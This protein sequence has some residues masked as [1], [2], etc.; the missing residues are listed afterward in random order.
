MVSTSPDPDTPAGGTA[1]SERR[2]IRRAGAQAEPATEA[3]AE[4]EPE[5]EPAAVADEGRALGDQIVR[6]DL[7]ATVV[8]GVVSIVAVVWSA[9]VVAAVVVDI[10]LFVAGCAAFVYAYFRGIGRSR[11]EAVSL[12]GLFF[13]AEGAAPKPVAR[14]LR[15]LLAAQVVLALATAAARPFS[16]LAFGVLAP[17]FGLAML[18]LWGAVHGRFTER[19]SPTAKAKRRRDQPREASE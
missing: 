11:E 9:A 12:A 16:S 15:L 13:L 19:P 8:F 7:W 1:P 5:A 2:A 4:P 3:T 14:S 6:A 10:A 17:M 18:G